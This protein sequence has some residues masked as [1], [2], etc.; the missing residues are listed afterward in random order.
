[1]SC[2]GYVYTVIKLKLHK[3]DIPIRPVINNKTATAYKLTRYLT[4][5]LDQYISLNN[6]FNVTN[7]TKLAN[8][9]TNLEINENHRMISFDIKHL[10]VNIT[11]DET[12]NIIKNKLLQNNNFQI[13]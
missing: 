7:S 1:M 10:C 13:T 11:I 12:L 6:N 3:T 5:T 9:L 8:D 2:R 4:K